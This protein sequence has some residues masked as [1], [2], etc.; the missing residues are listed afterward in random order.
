[1]SEPIQYPVPWDQVMSLFPHLKN[2]TR[3]NVDDFSAKIVA[4]MQPGPHLEGLENLPGDPR[5]ILVANHYQRK[6]L[7]IIHVA[8]ALTQ[9]VAERYGRRQDPPVHWMVTANWPPLRFGPWSM[10]SPGDWLLPKVAHALSCFPVSFAGNNPAYTASTLKRILK[11]SEYLQRPIGLFPEGVAGTAG[12][13]TDPLPGL[14]R[15]L[16]LLAKRG[17]PA[18]PAGISENGRFV[19]RFGSLVTAEELL[20]SPNSARLLMSRIAEMIQ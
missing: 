12:N 15:F 11:S 14:E 2:G 4:K 18:V 5:F 7:W 9:A 13:L 10:P 3:R 16:P 20:A 1:M 6:G 17:W 19:I 8:S